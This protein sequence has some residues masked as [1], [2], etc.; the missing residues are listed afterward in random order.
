MLIERNPLHVHH[1]LLPG[2]PG[3]ADL[4]TRG[5]RLR[6]RLGRRPSGLQPD[7]RPPPDGSRPPSRCRRRRRGRPTMPRRSGLRVAA[8]A[9]GHNAAPL[10]GSVD[11]TLLVDVRELRSIAIDAAARR[12]RV[13]AGVRWQDVVPQLSDLGL[14]ALHGSSPLVGIAGYSLGGGM[15]WLARKYGLQTN[16]VTALELVTADGPSG[17]RRRAARARPVLG[18]ARRQRQLRRRHRDRVR[19]L[20]RRGA[21]RRRHVLPRTSAPEVLHDWTGLAPA[22]ARGDD[23]LDVTA[24]LPG[25]PR[26]ARA[27]A[28]PAVHGVPRRLPRRGARR[29]GAAAARSATS[30]PR[31][32]RSRWC[33]PPRSPT[34]RWT[35][36][37]RCR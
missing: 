28:R 21:V 14:A 4:G 18:A 29:G 27:A 12:V 33:R 5:D 20:P 2:R 13:G 31:S 3:R 6:P 11:D 26:C 35:R 32:T 1:H 34:W 23:D 10:L 7:D 19:G 17:P 24:P 30:V 36:P 9:T 37:S 15:G 8:Q 22:L 16:S 25:H